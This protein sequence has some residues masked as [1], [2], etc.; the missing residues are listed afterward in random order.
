MGSSAKNS[1]DAKIVKNDKTGNKPA[2]K[3]ASKA[4]VKK[5]PAKPKN[6]NPI[7]QIAE[8]TTAT[9]AAKTDDNTG[10]SVMGDNFYK[11]SLNA[12]VVENIVH[13]E[14]DS[15]KFYNP[16]IIDATESDVAG[17]GDE[18]IAS[19]RESIRSSGLMTPLIGRFKK[20]QENGVETTVVSV[21]N[22][23]RRFQAIRQLVEQNIPCFDPS[24]KETVPA[25]ELY[26]NIPF[27]IFDVS[28]DMEC[29]LLSFQEDKTKVKFG[30]GTE[31]RFVQHCRSKFIGDNEIL[32]MTGNSSVWLQ[33]TYALLDSLAD[34][35]HVL[36]AFFNGRID[37]GLAKHLA[38]ITD[39]ETRRRLMADAIGAA[40]ERFEVKQEKIVATISS[41]LDKIE[42]LTAEKV[43]HSYQGK[44]ELADEKQAQ[45]EALETQV[46][47]ATNKTRGANPRAGKSDLNKAIQKNGQEAD[48]E[49]VASNGR[50]SARWPEFFKSV[51][52]NGGALP[53]D[54]ATIVPDVLARY[55]VA[56]MKAVENTKGIPSDFI[57][58][59]LNKFSESGL[60]ND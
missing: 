29:Y 2:P 18:D 58:D 59:W 24:T 40:F 1:K 5:E 4:L 33:D 16:R 37:R 48:D 21:I 49:H 47:Q 55:S 50:I 54:E 44:Q 46:K 38:S 15:L 10:Y 34:D 32:K 8:T 28:D 52:A 11:V 56:L 27:K 23:H 25:S 45:I 35:A 51:I 57:K 53:D 13:D 22:G 36:N 30:S 12:I 20:T 41:K 26:A 42:V 17:F 39:I 19:I 6:T 9:S 14:S 7:A 3:V 43:V 60:N 31:A